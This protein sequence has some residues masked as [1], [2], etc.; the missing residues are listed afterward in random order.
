[1]QP[2]KCFW[3]LSARQTYI[4]DKGEGRR[5][6]NL[7]LGNSAA[8]KSVVFQTWTEPVYAADDDDHDA[9]MMRF[10]ILPIF[11]SMLPLST[12]KTEGG[13]VEGGGHMFMERNS[14]APAP[15]AHAC[16]A[17]LLLFDRQ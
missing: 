10:F 17:L 3:V 15:L 2:S 9:M 1:M 11:Y 4:Y 5:K 13:W 8:I 16:S 14:C 6:G 12:V 7:S